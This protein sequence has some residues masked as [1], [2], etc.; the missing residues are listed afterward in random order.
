M[1]LLDA[2]MRLPFTRG[3]WLRFPIGSVEHKVFHGIYPY[4]HYAYGVYWAAFNARQLGIQR[5]SAIEFGVA[6]GRGL[7][8]LEQASRE[9]ESALGV[10]IDVVGFDSGTGMPRPIDYRDLPHVWRQGFFPMDEAQLRSRLERAALV[11][12]DVGTTVAAWVAAP[13]SPVGFVSFDLDFYSSTKAAFRVFESSAVGYLPRVYCYFDDIASN[14]L[15]LVNEY[16]GELLAILEYNDEHAHKKLT[17]I[18]QLREARPRW[19]HWQD[20]MFA[21]HDFEHPLYTTQ[22]VPGIGTNVALPL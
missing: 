12:G 16:V 2:V 13:H 19:E 10:G 9:I 15:S 3:L 1:S 22:V 21:H 11:L 14:N 4:P 5:I 20:R 7:V 6:G 18:E 8:A 17:K